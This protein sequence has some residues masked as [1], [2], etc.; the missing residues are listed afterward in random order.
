[1]LSLVRDHAVCKCTY[2]LTTEPAMAIWEYFITFASEVDIFW[3]KP[4]TAPSM[5]FVFARW[6]MM[7]NALMQ[8][9][10]V[11][12]ATYDSM[13]L[14]RISEIDTYL[15][16]CDALTWAA[17]VLYLAALIGTI[18]KQAHYTTTSPLCILNSQ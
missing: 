17:E 15:S 3:R 2:A 7:A 13:L 11:T 18:R 9:A 8:F 14:L 1:M 6:I 4:V 16:D 12:E 5:V 10:P